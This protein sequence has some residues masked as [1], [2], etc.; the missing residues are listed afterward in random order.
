[1]SSQAGPVNTPAATGEL[2]RV[3]DVQTRRNAELALLGFAMALVAAYSAT[4][5][6][7]MFDTITGNF[8]VPAAVLSVLFLPWHEYFPTPFTGHRAIANPAPSYFAGT[9]LASQNPGGSYAFA[10]E[11]PEHVFLDRLLGPPVARQRMGVALAGMAANRQM[12]DVAPAS[13]RN[14]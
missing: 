14:S 1:M 4:V 6:L 12:L 11:D 9:V 5:Q 3:R 13:S 10:A 7:T 2:P 8:W